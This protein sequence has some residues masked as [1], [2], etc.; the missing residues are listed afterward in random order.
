VRWVDGTAEKAFIARYF[1]RG[2]GL[3]VTMDMDGTLTMAASETGGC[4]LCGSVVGAVEDIQVRCLVREWEDYAAIEWTGYLQNLRHGTSP[5]LSDIMAA[6][7]EL[8]P[9]AGEVVVRHAHGS[10]SAPTDF[11]PIVTALGDGETLELAPAGGRSSDTA[12]PF[13]NITWDGGGVV[14]AIGWSGQWHASIGRGGDMVKLRVGQELTK[15]RLRP[16]EEIRTPKMLLVFWQGEDPQMGN[17][18][19]RQL[20]LDKYAP[21][22]DGQVFMPPITHSTWFSFNQGNDV[23]E[24]NQIA[25]ARKMAKMDAGLEV[26]W[27]DAGWFEGGWPGGAGSW[28]PKADNFPNGLR[29]LAEAVHEEGM[30]LCVWF[31]P[32][33]V[34]EGSRIATERPEFVLHEKTGGGGEFGDLYNLGDKA[35]REYLTGLLAKA[36]ADWDIDIYRHDFNIE[37]LGF[38]RAADEPE[39]QGIS[40]IRYVEGLYAMWDELARRKPGLFIDNCASGGRRIDLETCARSVPL[41]RSDTQSGETARPIVDQVQTAGLSMWVPLNSAGAWAFDP[42]SFWS[43]ATMGVNF[44]GNIT[45]EGFD[46]EGMRARAKEVLRWRELWL[47]DFWV[48]TDV[49]TSEEDWCAWQ[50]HD[51][52]AGKG[53]V[54][55]FRREKAEEWAVV[56][57][58]EI[59]ADRRYVVKD[60]YDGREKECGGEELAEMRVEVAQAPGVAVAEYRKA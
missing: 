21:R 6:D 1:A 59:E 23:T 26:F 3:P 12:L 51:P 52:E 38:W 29:P 57:L 27:L 54:M 48:L 17:N 8:G 10:T 34:T 28:V 37:P 58:R 43:V 25:A 22:R 39:R 56:R 40:E 13:L 18:L 19:L 11:L 35:A 47:K 2:N 50:M 30:K 15:L 55:A 7:V 4:P 9:V 5:L 20:L 14:A 46:V 49:T 32:E 16:M 31:E 41:W 36:V 33:R 44:C 60:V 45:A 53:V 24:E 42:Y